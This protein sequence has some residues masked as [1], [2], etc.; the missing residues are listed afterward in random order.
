MKIV[1]RQF[2]QRLAKNHD[3]LTIDIKRVL[4]RTFWKTIG[5]FRPEI[6]HY[7]QGP[8]LTS[9]VLIK[10]LSLRFWGVPIILSAIHPTRRLFGFQRHLIRYFR[11][12]IVLV[13][14]DET[15]RLFQ[16]AGCKTKVLFNGV[17]LKKFRPLGHEEKLELR[18]K[19]G[20]PSDRFVVLHIGTIKEGRNIRML[21]SV[22][23]SGNQVIVTGN[24]TIKNEMPLKEC[25]EENGCMIWIGYFSHIEEIYALADC[26][27][28]PVKPSARIECIEMP[29]SVMEAMACNLPI[30]A[31]RYGALPRAFKEGNGLRYFDP[32]N[33]ISDLIGV[34]KKGA[35]ISN[36]R[37]LVIPFDWENIVGSLEEIYIAALR[38]ER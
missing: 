14:S 17:D 32:E 29:L 34:I 36:T 7:T 11:P 10:M 33:Q 25:L 22:Q 28:F 26:Y 3:I 4:T 38:E 35:A 1:A 27:V 9:L 18:R 5:D 24:T 16:N 30:I 8:T 15:E 2:A 12:D 31:S 6:I 13:Q 37:S 19:F 21:T 23:N 20:I